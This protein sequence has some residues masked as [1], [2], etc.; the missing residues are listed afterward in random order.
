MHDLLCKTILL[1]SKQFVIRKIIIQCILEKAFK[2][3]TNSWGKTYWSVVTRVRF[4]SFF[5][6]WFYLCSFTR[7]WIFF[8][9]ECLVKENIANHS[10]NHPLFVDDTQLQK[11]ALLNEMTSPT[12]ELNACTDDIKTWMIENQLKLNDDK[13]EALPFPF[14]SSLKSST[15][16]LLDSITLALT[17]SPSLI[18]LGTLQFLDSNLSMKKPVIN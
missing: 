13:T 15:V 1:V 2:D 3:F 9:F 16:S 5:K 6:N 4:I 14:S 17:T 12:K 8:F 7:L 11:S 18:L 10:V